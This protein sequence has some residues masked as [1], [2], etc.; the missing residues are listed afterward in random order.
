MSSSTL[1]PGARLGK[2]QVLAH[3][4]TGGMGTVYKA[5]DM[6]LGRIVALKVLPS[7]IGKENTDLERFRNEARAAASLSHKHIVTFFD[8]HYE[9]DLD[10][11][12]LAMEFVDGVDLGRHL[13]TKG[14]LQPE[15]ARRILIQAGQAL[16]HAYSRGVIHR[17][18]KPSNFL[19]AQKGRKIVVKL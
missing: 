8:L 16:A 12:Y 5:V 14:R 15:D 10:L 9:E 13:E 19:L 6:A 1:P 17:D 4:A 3:I 11:H 18:V 7:Q 2:Y